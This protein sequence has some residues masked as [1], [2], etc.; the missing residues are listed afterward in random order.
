MSN[1]GKRDPVLWRKTLLLVVI[2]GIVVVLILEGGARLWVWRESTKPARAVAPPLKAHDMSELDK[3]HAPDPYIWWKMAPNLKDRRIAGRCWNRDV[4]FTLSTNDQGLRNPPL[5]PAGARTRVLAL[6]DSTTFGLGVDNDQTWPAQLQMLLDAEAGAERFEVLNAG[7]CGYSAFQGLRYLDKYGLDFAPAVVVACFGHNDFD[8]WNMQTDIEKAI[9]EAER[10][11]ANAEKSFSDFFVLARRALRQAG[12]TLHAAAGQKRPRLTP[13][14][15]H[16]TLVEMKK[17][18]DCEGIPILFVLWPY[19]WQVAQR[20]PD[21]V[22]YQVILIDVCKEI[23]ARLVNLYE[24][25]VA[26]SEPLYAD[27]VHGNPTGCGVAARAIAAEVGRALENAQAPQ[28][29]P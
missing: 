18:C 4:A 24:A 23:N 26:S 12:E 13:E 5:A 17:L 25:F 10:E 2:A 15:F 16:D 11:Q 20:S 6:G 7:V 9:E 8:T 29:G 3:V 28:E 1:A 19:E 21:P 14:E 22:Q 27:P